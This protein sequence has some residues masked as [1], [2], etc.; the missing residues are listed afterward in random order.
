MPDNIGGK[1]GDCPRIAP[2]V[3]LYPIA[4]SGCHAWPCDGCNGQILEH[5]LGAAEEWSVVNDLVLSFRDYGIIV[6]TAPVPGNGFENTVV[7]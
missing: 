1:I 3:V 6:K 4:I 7:P 2:G 5:I